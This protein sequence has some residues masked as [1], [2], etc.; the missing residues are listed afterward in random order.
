LHTLICSVI[1]H[2]DRTQFIE[3]I[4]SNEKSVPRVWKELLFI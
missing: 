4:H 3:N 2:I 1:T